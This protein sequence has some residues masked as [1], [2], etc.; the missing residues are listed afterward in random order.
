MTSDDVF[1]RIMN[2]E[3]NIQEVNNIKNLYKG[4]ST[5]KEQDI[6]LKANKIKKKKIIKENMMK[7]QWLYSSR[8][9]TSSLRKED[10]TREKGKGS[11]C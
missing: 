10:L 7:M 8:N 9:S 4:V 11:Q 2:H 5:S 1:E 6:G 3:M